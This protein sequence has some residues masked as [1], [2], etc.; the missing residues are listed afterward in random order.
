MKNCLFLFLFGFISL[1]LLAQHDLTI[2][3]IDSL[4]KEDLAGVIIKVKNT[5][6]NN[7]TDLN[8]EAV[9]TGI[10]DG[11]QEIVISY[12][13]YHTRTVSLTFP[14]TQPG[15]ILVTLGEANEILDEVR[16][17]ST[18][19]NSRIEDIPLKVE[20]IGQDDTEEENGI[21]P[22]NVSSLL[23]DVS[24]IQIQQTSASSGNSNVRIQGLTGA[25]TQLLRD[26]IPMYDGFSSDFGI[27]QLPP[28]D[29]KQIE[30]VKG[31]ASTLY[32]GGAIAGLINLIT[33]DPSSVRDASVTMNYSSLTERNFNLYSAQR[34]RKNGYT[35]FTGYTG[36]NA[37]DVDG[38]GFSDVPG[39][40]YGTLHPKFYH[41]FSDSTRLVIGLTGIYEK[42]KGGDMQVLLGSPDSSHV[43]YERQESWRNMADLLFNSVR[44]KGTW[45]F[46]AAGA[47]L[48]RTQT[49]SD[50]VFGGVQY[51][52][53]SELSY[54]VTR[55]KYDL[56]VGANYITDHF[57]VGANDH[58]FIHTITNNTAGFFVQHTWR[59]GKK[60]VLETGVRADGHS[61]RGVFPLPRMAMMYRFSKIFSMRLN[62]GL[63]YKVPNAF[64]KQFE[65]Y[66]PNRIIPI[67][68][69]V[70]SEKSLGA[71]LEFIWKKYFDNGVS[72]FADQSFFYTT[73]DNPV[74]PAHTPYGDVYFVNAGGRTTSA[75]SDTYVRIRKEDLEV[76]LGY[77]YTHAEQPYDSVITT[78]PLFPAHRFATVLAYEL[79]NWRLGLEGS[80]FG[81]QFTPDGA[82]KPGYL[83]MAAMIGHQAGNMSIVLNG[84][85]L[86][87][88]RQPRY[89]AVVLPPY[90]HPTF[91]TLW[92]PIDGRTINLSVRVK[93]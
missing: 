15:S 43:Y 64:A 29:L 71:G 57:Q 28:L 75:G 47:R 21:K 63:G 83:F 38:D 30:I 8:G 7:V 76:Y 68:D 48:D 41:Y 44:K 31:S 2:K 92:A 46:K 13:G 54:L 19:T 84:E 32:G 3:V 33:K 59:I 53:F 58:A 34:F 24:G 89:E 72:F 74:V 85:N 67:S 18:R 22:G 51:H 65:E 39:T 88:Y 86:L 35:L 61:E 37:V 20:V 82:K 73:I 14:L 78:M 17:T 91:R 80:Y 66:D 16:I 36:Q 12:V 93:F 60:F 11:R 52:L 55:E 6:L 10:P 42:R 62:S 87:D 49:T 25:Y 56:V 50:Y 90:S 23:G 1:P 40:L 27:M 9:L 70:R 81:S 45:N 69:T 77:T 5:A 26:G 4:T 79:E